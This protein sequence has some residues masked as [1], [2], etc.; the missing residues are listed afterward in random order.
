MENVFKRHANLSLLG[1]VLFAQLLGLAV[2]IKV[3]T[4]NGS[5]RLIRRWTV[6]VIS[7]LQKT[8]IHTNTTLSRAW[9]GYFWLRDVRRENEELRAKLDAMHLEQV[10]LREDA[11]QGRRLQYLL[12]FKEQHIS[13]TVAAQVIGSS[14][15]EQSRVVYID[16][17]SN[18]GLR[19]DLA[20]ITPQGVVGKT[21]EIYP[22]TSQ[23][24]LINDQS[25]GIGAIL[26]QS[27]LQGILKG[28]PGGVTMLNYIMADEKIQAGDEVVTSGG[29]RIFP[30]GLPIGKVSSVSPGKEMFLAI[31]V[32]PAANLSQIEEVLVITEVK[33]QAP[34][35][36]L[37]K[38]PVRAS[39]ILAERL[40][41]VPPKPVAPAAGENAGTGTA[42]AVNTQQ[43]SSAV[44]KPA[45]VTSS[46][47]PKPAAENSVQT[48]ATAVRKPSATTPAVSG[49]PP[50]SKPAA[51]SVSGVPKPAGNVPGGATPQ[52]AQKPRSVVPGT[53]ATTPAQKAPD[54]TTA[55]PKASPETR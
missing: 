50:I 18:D 45:S 54:D 33:E 21:I 35:V 11:E 49:T 36:D 32:A 4:E 53:T 14:G 34:E 31:R 15:S 52:A 28:A 39:D 42:T 8:F 55:V 41:S 38:G 43:G 26:T 12:A 6:A 23:V 7:P 17:G 48:G 44:P 10:R 24:L 37:S 13:K 1:I 20:V 9:H 2:Q 51:V 29:D 5:T 22:T 3:D 25:S 16:K 46:Q 19:T 27:R 47:A 40:P 30:K